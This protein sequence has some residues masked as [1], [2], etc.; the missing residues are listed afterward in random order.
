M[1]AGGNHRGGFVGLPTADC[2]LGGRLWHSP[3]G[4][5]GLLFGHAVFGGVI[6]H[7]ARGLRLL[8]C[9]VH[10]SLSRPQFISNHRR[11]LAAGNRV[12]GEGVPPT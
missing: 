2:A 10:G 8:D 4:G 11:A 12:H 1:E 9:G 7:P 3:K 5:A 6:Y